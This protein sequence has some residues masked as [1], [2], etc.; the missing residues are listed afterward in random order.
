V[1]GTS[2]TLILIAQ[3]QDFRAGTGLAYTGDGEPVPMKTATGW[4]DGHTTVSTVHPQ[5]DG[6]PTVDRRRLC[7]DNQHTAL[8]ARDRGCCF[9][10]CHRP[11]QHTEAHHVTDWIDGGRTQ[12]KN[13]ALV[14]SYHHR[15]HQAEGW[16]LIMRDHH[17]WWRPPAWIDP[18]RNLIRN[19][20]HDPTA[21]PATPISGATTP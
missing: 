2:S 19:Y 5:P 13:L 16:Q 20:L 6:N 11:P 21:A 9:P 7:T 12:V 18:Q 14:C 3:E 8:I 15:N 10:G 17:P 4:L 1:G